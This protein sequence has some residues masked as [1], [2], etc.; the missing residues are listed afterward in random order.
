M[1]EDFEREERAFAE[2]LHASVP[3]ETFRPLDAE[4]I[5]AAARPAQP[6]RRWMRG[7]AAAAVLVVTVGVGSALLPRMAGTAGSV[8]AEPA[9]SYAAGG[10]VPEAETARAAD[11]RYTSAS[12]TA[13]GEWKSI[14]APSPLSPRMYASGGWLNGKFYIVGGRGLKDGCSPKQTFCPQDSNNLTDGASYDLVTDSWQRLP[15]SPRPVREAAPVAV[16]TRLYYSDSASETP[17]A[18]LA[19]DTATN[20]WQQLPAPAQAGQ[21]VAAGDRLINVGSASGNVSLDQVFDPVTGTWSA[22]PRGR[23]ATAEWRR[24]VYA[25]GQ[26]IV[27]GRSSSPGDGTSPEFEAFD[28]AT[29]TWH[30]LSQPAFATPGGTHVGDYVVFGTYEPNT[31]NAAAPQAGGGRYNLVT[32]EWSD[33]PAPKSTVRVFTDAYGQVVGDRILIK[34]QLFDPANGSWTP[35]TAPDPKVLY[36]MTVIGSPGGLLVFGGEDH[37]KLTN[38]TYYLQVP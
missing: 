9:A 12:G 8:H 23:F 20:T 34:S 31:A 3:V 32:G 25:G 35:L 29:N 15:D 22:L 6:A 36:G 38:H 5:K 30:E 18:P 17:V 13:A 4:A 27:G 33:L 26:L 28:F 11:T 1:N 14:A 19:F 37:D 7:L 10:A 16:G 24:G 21:L 2:A